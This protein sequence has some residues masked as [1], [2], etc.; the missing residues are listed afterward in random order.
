LSDDGN[1]DNDT[2]DCDGTAVKPVG[3]VGGVVSPVGSPG[4]ALVPALTDAFAERFP[5]A[6]YASTSRV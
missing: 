1:H 3:V 2:L 5:A 4:H 6:S